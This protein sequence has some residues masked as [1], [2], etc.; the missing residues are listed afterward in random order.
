[1]VFPAR[2]TELT[3]VTFPLPS[4]F[5]SEIQEK[6]RNQEPGSQRY[7]GRVLNRKIF[8]VITREDTLGQP[9]F[10]VSYM[11]DTYR[12][13]LVR[14]LFARLTRLKVIVFLFSWLLSLWLAHYLS[15]PLAHCTI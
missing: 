10:L 8:Y 6:A 13:G 11:W 14:T 2:D 7:S 4:D 12:E 5:I 15:R 1:M 3:S 9:V